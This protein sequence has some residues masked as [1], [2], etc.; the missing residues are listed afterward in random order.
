MTALEYMERQV[1]KR[2]L[3]YYHEFVREVPE[4]Q[5][6]NIRAKIGY[7]EA[8]VEAL[9]KVG[10]LS[11]RLIDADAMIPKGTKVTDDVIVIHDAITKAPTIDAVPVVRCKDCKYFQDNNSGYPHDECRWGKGETPDPDDFCSYGERKDG[12]G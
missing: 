4:E 6:Q 11:M 5:L 2:R 1:E 9:R 3:N 7:Y 8:A 12:E 10:G